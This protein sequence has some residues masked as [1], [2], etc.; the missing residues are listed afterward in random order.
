[1]G[2]AASPVGDR[3]WQC[4]E[5]RAWIL[6]HGAGERLG[7]EVLEAPAHDCERLGE[8]AAGGLCIE[9]V[10]ALVPNTRDGG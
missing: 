6:L 8:R 5:Q 3:S 1:M 7:C 2:G 10:V 4:A 9:A